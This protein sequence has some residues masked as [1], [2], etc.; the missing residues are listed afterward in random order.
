[1]E[2]D[3]GAH[4]PLGSKAKLPTCS[5]SDSAELP[6]G[7]R[8]MNL[9]RVHVANFPRRFKIEC[10][11]L[12]QNGTSWTRIETVDVHTMFHTQTEM[13]EAAVDEDN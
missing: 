12:E 10:C 2:A 9:C 7:D 3:G 1:M 6:S 5:D 13:S 8:K 4:E 11:R